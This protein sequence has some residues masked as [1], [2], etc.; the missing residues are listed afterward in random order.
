[1]NV[2]KRLLINQM[3]GETPSLSSECFGSFA[4]QP[5]VKIAAISLRERKF[6]GVVWRNFIS[7]VLVINLIHLVCNTVE[8]DASEVMHM[9]VQ[10]NAAQWKRSSLY[11]FSF[12]LF[13]SSI[14][15]LAC[16]QNY[17]TKKGREREGER[18]SA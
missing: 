6:A 18:K 1:M 2:S 3:I 10:Q 14:K 15:N 11:R 9:A 17:E 16:I 7:H 13:Q 12:S 8:Q 5:F 4:Q